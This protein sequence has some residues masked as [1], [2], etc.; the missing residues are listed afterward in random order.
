MDISPAFFFFLFLVFWTSSSELP[1]AEDR[2]TISVSDY[3]CVLILD[4]VTTLPERS[5][6]VLASRSTRDVAEESRPEMRIA[7]IDTLM[8]EVCACSNE[9]SL[10]VLVALSIV[11]IHHQ[12]CQEKSRD[13]DNFMFGMLTLGQHKEEIAHPSHSASATLRDC[14]T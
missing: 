14:T 13:E 1:S 10:S 8:S 6:T 7:E 4:C 5:F 3:A 11:T 12:S 2:L 9:N